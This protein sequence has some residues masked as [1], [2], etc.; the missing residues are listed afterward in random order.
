[1]ALTTDLAP[2]RPR[3]YRGELPAAPLLFALIVV[4]WYPIHAYWQSDDFLALHYTQ[5]LRATLSDFVGPQ[6]GLDG[7]ALF[8]RPFITLSFWIEQRLFGT[9]PWVS[10]MSNTLAH[11]VSACLV[12]S[13]AARFAGS[14][15]GFLA[16]LVFGLAPIHTG[17]ILWAVGRVDSHTTMWLLL[18]CVFTLR[19]FERKRCRLWPALVC[20]VLALGSKESAIVL[21]VV[22]AALVFADA[23]RRTRW[24]RTLR[25]WP[26]LACTA[27]F[28]C[29]R[30]LALGHWI[31]GYSAKPPIVPT[32][33]AEG[34]ASK[35]W[36]C[37]NPMLM[38]RGDL[39]DAPEWIVHLGLLP[40]V[41]ATVYLLWR[42]R[43][44]ALAFAL[45]WFAFTALPAIHSFGDADPANLRLFYLPFAGFAF[46]IG[47]SGPIVTVAMLA[48]FALPTV[49]L[50]RDYYAA[51]R[52][53]RRT[54]DQLRTAAAELEGDPL[55][56]AGLPRTNAPRNTAVMFQVG[57]DR[58]L[59]EPFVPRPALERTVLALRPLDAR[60][61]SLRIPYG[62]SSGLPFDA[63]TLLVDDGGRIVVGP[64]PRPGPL[65]DLE[66]RYDG[67]AALTRRFLTD[68]DGGRANASIAVA[69]VRATAWRVTLFTAGGYLTC[70][71][72]DHGDREAGDGLIALRDVLLARYVAAPGA[73]RAHVFLALEVPIALDLD[74]RFP[75]LVEALDAH[76][77]PTGA[78]RTPLWIGFDREVAAML[79]TSHS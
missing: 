55:F 35:A 11:A 69:G 22:A 30:R 76:G 45:A 64:L 58:L 37:M 63:P 4:A 21:P 48:A 9:D 16:G 29:V 38:L 60:P 40:F 65:A 61:D 5:S 41:A 52:E 54:H 7:V 72:S 57:V 18:A 71:V 32:A 23:P 2:P 39:T 17:S 79:G 14:L 27:A 59:R 68:L 44:D 77:A 26:L 66:L 20:G 50:H 78:N 10:H 56:V 31:G 12:G 3:R 13:I 33:A 53:A 73:D 25:T 74:T 75:V 24:H 67:P 51:F 36:H 34:L 1:M 43:M 47:A 49:H 6:Y 19:R 46:V 8:Y 15:K 62:E 70:I 42:R 28:V